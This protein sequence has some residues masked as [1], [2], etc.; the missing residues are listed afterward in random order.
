MLTLV[1][2]CLGDEL[3]VS[4]HITAEHHNQAAVLD[5]AGDRRHVLSSRVEGVAVLGG[6]NVGVHAGQAGLAI[7]G[8]LQ[9]KASLNQLLL[10]VARTVVPLEIKDAVRLAH[11]EGDA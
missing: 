5:E 11:V 7:S 9:V 1:A 8:D 10:Q 2:Q 4:L 6:D 3:A